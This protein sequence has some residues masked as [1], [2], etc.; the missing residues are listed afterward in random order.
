M[1]PRVIIDIE[2]YRHNL[3]HMLDEAHKRG[4]SVMA[5]SKVFCADTELLEVMVEEQVDFIADSRIENLKKVSTTI[6]KVLLRLPMQSELE[7]VVKHASISLN[8]EIDTIADINHICHHL[9]LTHGVILM[10]DLGDLREGIFIEEEIYNTVEK[11][12]KM[13]HIKLEGIGTNLTCFGGVI[14]T[15]ET[16]D[17]LLRYKAVIEERFDLSLNI[18]SGGN[19]SSIE[20]LLNDSLPKEI[21]NLRL[22]EVIV[23]G[24]ETA[25]GNEVDNMYN[26]VFTLEAEIIEIKE[27]PSVPIGEIGMNAFGKV[28]IFVDKGMMLRAILALGKQ[29]VDYQ[30]LIP[31][32]T[33]TCIGS[34]SDHII[35][36]ISDAYNI[37]NVGDTILFRLTYSSVL[38][39]MTSPYVKKVYKNES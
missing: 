10:I 19:S 38:S 12:L 35:V 22:G 21:N 15:R 37:Y 25:Y 36:D 26:D 34:S 13:K 27:K 31:Y 9:N 28:P 18:I 7:E 23:L 16:Y 17:S 24:R 29:D 11:I 4:V 2:K 30:E 33:V 32:D 39:L 3:R 14:P 20:L 6:P 8:S 5:V 1:Y